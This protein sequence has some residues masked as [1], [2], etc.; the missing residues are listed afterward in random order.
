LAHM[1]SQSGKLIRLGRILNPQTS[2]GLAIAYSHGMLRGAM[3]GLRT[4]DEMMRVLEAF[5]PADAVMVTPG[6][7]EC[8]QGLFLRR[9]APARI[10][11]VGGHNV[12]RAQD[13]E[14]GV[15]SG[16]STAVVT[17]AQAVAA[18]A[19]AIMTY[20]WLGGSSPERERDEV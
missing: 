13:G 11:Q 4:R 14:F 12:G 2:R 5:T 8:T 6:M 20:L 7:V 19:D 9:Q 10:V 17:V 3:P 18:G 16:A 1:N 15:Q